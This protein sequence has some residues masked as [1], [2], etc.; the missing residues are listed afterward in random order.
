[1]SNQIQ[2]SNFSIM[3]TFS[4]NQSYH[5]TN[6]YLFHI[7]G[8]ALNEALKIGWRANVNKSLSF[9]KKYFLY[10]VDWCSSIRQKTCYFNY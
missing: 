8:D 4:F 10:F 3:K 1:M 2:E 5:N 9:S 7:L 6:K